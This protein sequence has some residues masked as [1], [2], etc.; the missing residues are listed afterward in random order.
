MPECSSTNTSVTNDL[1]FSFSNSSTPSSVTASFQY[2]KRH[3][4]ESEDYLDLQSILNLQEQEQKLKKQ[5]LFL[6]LQMQQQQHQEEREKDGTGSQTPEQQQQRQEQ[7]LSSSSFP[8]IPITPGII[9]LTHATPIS[10]T[11]NTTTTTITT[12]DITLSKVM[13]NPFTKSERVKLNVGGKIFETTKQTFSAY[14]NSLLGNTFSL[15]KLTKIGTMFQPRN[16]DIIPTDTDH[17]FFDRNPKI[18]EKV[19]E[20]YR[21]GT[22][23]WNP[24]KMSLSALTA[25]FDYFQIP[26]ASELLRE[27]VRIIATGE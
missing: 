27:K 16:R 13:P 9:P 10:T 5:Q 23:D 4:R 2:A 19:L 6:L 20:F 8:A 18:F 7:L 15:Y 22:V 3:E 17:Y 1:E 26:E 14:P 21:T 11:G 25:E 24:D 12:S